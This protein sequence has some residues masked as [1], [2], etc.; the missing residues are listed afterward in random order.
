M[1]I[2]PCQEC[3]GPVSDK[4]EHC[5][6]CGAKQSK[7]TSPVVILLAVL[8]MGAG[9]I[10]FMTPRS[11]QNIESTQAKPLTEQDIMAARQMQAYITIKNSMK[12]PD[13]AKINFYKGK[14][15]GQVNAK[16]SFGAYTG[17]KRIVLLKDINIEGQNISDSQFDKI[18]KKY[19]DGVNF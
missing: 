1:T 16:N 10:A 5:P 15:C 8:L 11:E 13:S 6:R 12:D 14:P 19:C 7:K 18:W 4:A 9:V 3:G 2:K 17:F